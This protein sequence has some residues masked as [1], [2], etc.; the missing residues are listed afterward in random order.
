MDGDIQTDK[1]ADSTSTDCP[2]RAT[3]SAGVSNENENQCAQKIRVYGIA[4]IPRKQFH[5]TILVPSS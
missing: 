1:L 4:K 2:T 3:A 5:R